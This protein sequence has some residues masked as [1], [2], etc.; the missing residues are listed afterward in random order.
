MSAR[1]GL[2]EVIERA[3]ISQ[4]ELARMTGLSF[5][6]IHRLCTN[7]TA[8]VHLETLDKIMSALEAAKVKAT[9]EDIV[10]RTPKGRA[11]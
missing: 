1:F 7:A 9:L 6:T 11:R 8:Q 3:D 4:S 5:A 2:R 10:V